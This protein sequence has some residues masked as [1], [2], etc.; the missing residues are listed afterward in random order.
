MTPALAT[1]GCFWRWGTGT[2]GI[3]PRCFWVRRSSTA[4]AVPALQHYQQGRVAQKLAGRRQHCPQRPAQ[5]TLKMATATL[6]TGPI[7]LL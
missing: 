2:S 7:I 3:S 6:A 1:I 5:Q 4:A